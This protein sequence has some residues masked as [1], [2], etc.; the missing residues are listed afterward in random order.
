[1]NNNIHINKYLS[2]LP[3]Y[4]KKILCKAPFNSI[5]LSLNGKIQV[6]CAN[7]D[8]TLGLYP[9]IKIKDAWFGEKINILRKHI[10]DKDLSLGCSECA[11]QIN[12][13]A[14][15]SVKAKFYNHLRINKNGYPSLIEFELDNICNLECIMC[16]PHTSSAILNHCDL[17][18]MKVTTYSESLID[19]IE[20]FIPHLS[21]A[22]FIGG[23]PFLIPI[24]YTLIEKMLS[25]NPYIIFN[26][27]TNGTILNEK[28]KKLI[29]RGKF[30][31]AVSVDSIEKETYEKIRKNAS[32]DEVK[33]NI[34]FFIEYCRSKNTY[35]SI[36]V[37]PMTINAT[38]IPDLVKYFDNKNIP[39]YFNTVTSPHS[40]AL[41]YKSSKELNSIK[42]FYKKNGLKKNN[43]NSRR[44][45]DL[46][47]QINSWEIASL[48]RERYLEQFINSNTDEIISVFIQNLSQHIES[49]YNEES[50]LK[51]IINKLYSVL[52][53]KSEDQVREIIIF[54][55]SMPISESSN[56]I[57]ANEIDYI[58]YYISK[59][60]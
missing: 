17:K 46:I 1:M 26:I 37:C 33:N 36:W 52:N 3:F 49:I 38:E 56:I 29:F 47:N 43:E 58:N 7:K 25:I 57:I 16:N 12:S 40:L 11:Y 51:L 50:F 59:N 42:Q 9:E 2:T 55:L 10:K 4:K 20:E 41:W 6:C 35:F 22:N 24:Y 60:F 13:G 48:E 15:S 5:R 53:D 45:N 23:E 39:V 28:I 8:F 44:F 32:F 18:S 27:S 14:Y 21:H 34:Q 19:E 30:D 31:I 54:M